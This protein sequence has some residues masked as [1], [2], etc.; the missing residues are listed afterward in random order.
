[1]RTFEIYIQY[2]LLSEIFHIDALA[3]VLVALSIFIGSI[4]ASFSTRYMRGDSCYIKFFWCLG[5]LIIAESLLVILDNIWLFGL[6]FGLCDCLLVIMIIHKPSWRAAKESGLFALK[7]FA[8]GWSCLAAAFILLFTATSETSISKIVQI[9]TP[10][11]EIQGALVLLIISALVQS[12][13]W[14]FSKWILSSMNAPMPVSALMHAG[15]V[16]AGGFLLLRFSPLLTQLPVLL[17]LIFILGIITAFIGTFWKLVQTDV[18]RMLACSTIA[19]MGF[20]LAQCG[21]GLYSVAIAHIVWHALF[22]VYLFLSSPGSFH[23]KKYDLGYPPKTLP[24]LMSLV[25]GFIGSMCFSYSKEIPLS[26]T[27]T[28]LLL[29]VVSFISCTQLTLTLLGNN[30]LKNFVRAALISALAALLYGSSIQ[31]MENTLGNAFM[32]PEPINYFHIASVILFVLAWI[33]VLYGKCIMKNSF[34]QKTFARVY[35]MAVNSSRPHSTTITAN[36]NQYKYV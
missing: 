34:V 25:G 21:L 6:V 29:L 23:E 16:S 2:V 3:L 11:W 22:K 5:I 7:N 10:S 15:L 20:M 14:P 17:T 31:I 19:Q 13:A 26:C 33:L 18:K 30:P 12:A 1:M 9:Q 28:R 8:F 35:V 32:Q 24:F 27:D 36:R 4:V